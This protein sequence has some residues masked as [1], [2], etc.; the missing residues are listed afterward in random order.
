[1]VDG[2]GQPYFGE[3][4]PQ[5][6]R[7][8]YLDIYEYRSH[9]PIKVSEAGPMPGPPGPKKAMA[10]AGADGLSP[11]F[12]A[13]LVAVRDGPASPDAA[14][15]AALLE[16]H[17]FGRTAAAPAQPVLPETNL[18]SRPVAAASSSAHRTAS[19]ETVRVL[20]MV[21]SAAK[22]P[23]PVLA[24]AAPWSGAC[25]DPPP[26]AASEAN[27]ARL[28]AGLSQAAAQ[29]RLVPPLRPEGFSLAEVIAKVNAPLPEAEVGRGQY[30]PTREAPPPPWRQGS[31]VPTKAAVPV[32]LPWSPPSTVAA[33]RDVEV[34]PVGC[35][36]AAQVGPNLWADYN[37]QRAQVA[38]KGQGTVGDDEQGAAEVQV[39]R[40]SARQSRW[41]D[42][43][44][45]LPR[46]KGQGRASGSEEVALNVRLL[47][48]L[49]RWGGK[50][51]RFRAHLDPQGWARLEDIGRET[52]RSGDDTLWFA[53]HCD[54]LQVFHDHEQG[55][56]LIRWWPEGAQGPRVPKVGY[57][58]DQGIFVPATVPFNIFAGAAEPAPVEAPQVATVQRDF[59]SIAGVFAAPDLLEDDMVRQQQV[60]IAALRAATSQAEVMA[61]QSRFL[62]SY[63]GEVVAGHDAGAHVLWQ[64]LPEYSVGFPPPVPMVPWWQGEPLPG[65]DAEVKNEGGGSAMV[66]VPEV[67][68]RN[69]EAGVPHC[70]PPS[71]PLP[72]TKLA[73]CGPAPPSQ[74]QPQAQQPPS[75]QPQT[76]A[77]SAE[78]GV[79]A[80]R[81]GS[82]HNKASSSQMLGK[83]SVKVSRSP[84]HS[85]DERVRR[86][87]DRSP[88]SSAEPDSRRK[89]RGRHH[90]R[91]RS[92]RGGR[93]DRR[94]G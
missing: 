83:K 44:A 49:L 81:T 64:L 34:Q 32:Q 87:R 18:W 15:A 66:L 69:A 47:T 16:K 45:P 11:A 90:N 77:G 40:P 52:G 84:P 53:G 19:S 56:V 76:P 79:R 37:T 10:A 59:G 71:R 38:G 30:D 23:P 67:E 54:S 26:N 92:R 31:P 88:S 62:Q 80:G 91:S 61:I 85:D 57:L 51:R 24:T 7:Y 41:N 29:Q 39:P 35:A 63:P 46:P 68:G 58:G 13:H 60:Y 70:P 75:V 72:H 94:R 1:M 3:E 27:L 2:Q 17:G 78:V 25:Q 21:R 89:S 93:H 9:L 48:S 50:D 86:N 33:L 6:E 8:I 12:V 20:G 73:S 22:V 5:A 82:R 28:R 43:H 4:G 55:E 36:A 14:A 74:Q 65:H 42:G